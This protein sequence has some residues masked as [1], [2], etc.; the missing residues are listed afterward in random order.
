MGL[1]GRDLIWANFH[2]NKTKVCSSLGVRKDHG[3]RVHIDWDSIHLE[4][5]LFLRS[6]T[7]EEIMVLL[8]QE[9]EFIWTTLH[10]DETQVGS[11]LGVLEDHRLWV[12]VDWDS[13][14]LDVIKSIDSIND[15]I[16]LFEI[17]VGSIIL[18]ESWVNK[19]WNSLSLNQR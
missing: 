9:G 6:L 4:N 16:S 19:Y 2:I 12:N 10:I 7:L 18:N 17:G 3:L 14:C 13:V 15:N 11:C 8:H 5:G 1:N